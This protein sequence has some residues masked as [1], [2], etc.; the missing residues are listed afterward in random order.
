[1]SQVWE[2]GICNETAGFLFK[3]ACSRLSERAC[4]LCGK[5][6]CAEHAHEAQ[7]QTFCTSCARQYLRT[8]DQRSGFHRDDPYF[9]AGSYYHGYG[10]YG[11][12]SWGSSHVHHADTS[13]PQH[14]PH[15]F[16]E[17]DAE[18]LRR[19]DDEDFEQDMG[20]S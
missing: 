16:T 6:V 5:P 2:Q 4:G 17:A 8:P 9:Y 12:G 14:D 18:S 11:H 1:M 10:R 15:D 20:E 19:E 3:H 13:S 7:G